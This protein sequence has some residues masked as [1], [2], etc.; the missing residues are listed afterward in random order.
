MTDKSI[1][2]RQDKRTDEPDDASRQGIAP[3]GVEARA[4]AGLAEG[5]DVFRDRPLWLRYLA[6]LALTVVAVGLRRWLDTLGEGVVAF[7]LFYLVVLAC[8]FFGGVGPGLVS[9]GA[10]AVAVTIFWL[11]PVG[12]L[13]LSGTTPINLAL[14]ILTSGVIILIAHLLRAAHSRLRQSEARLS[15][16]QDVGRI[17]V[18]ELDLRSGEPWWSPMFYEVTGISPD[19][20]SGVRSFLDRIDPADR[21]RAN[22]AFEAARDGRDKL[23]AQFRFNRD[24]GATVWLTTR[25]ELFRDADGQPSRLL[26]ITFDV[27]SVRAIESERNRAHTLLRTFFDSLPGAAYV[28]DAEGRILLGNPG[29]AAAVG[30]APESFLG[31]TDPEFLSDAEFA[32]A[33]VEH[34]RALLREGVSRQFEEDLVLPDGELSHWLSVKTP[35]R[36]AE[37][38]IA[39]LVG[40]SLDMTERRRA[41]RR[42]RFLANEV[43]HRAKN[44]MG[45]VQSIVRLTR[46]D[47]IAG[48]KEALTG[49][50][51]ALAR[52]HNLLAASRWEGVELGTLVNEELAP[53]VRTRGAQIRVS[54]PTVKLEPSASQAVTMALH[55][56]AINAARYGAL[57]VESGELTVAWQIVDRG[58]R[59]CLELVWTEARGP[60]VASRV[61]PGFGSTAIRG[62]IEH[63]LGGEIDIDWAPTGVVCRIAFPVAHSVVQD[64]PVAGPAGR[65]RGAGTATSPRDTD[66][67]GKRVLIL[68]DEALIAIT[69]KEAVEALGCE[70]VGPAGNA[71]AALDLIKARAPE[72]AILDVNLAGAS[73]AP[74]AAALR[75]L[76]I[77]FVY[78]TGYAEPAGQIEP[79]L[80]AAMLTKPVDPDELAAA[81]QRALEG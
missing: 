43:D 24:D 48:F 4:Y 22:A 5:F 59:S 20:A 7:T 16:S 63:Q 72:L 2:A 37:G 52:A 74:V 8:T 69:L 56:L 39:G 76:D 17:G 54:G 50:I 77:P 40:I 15:L 55:E 73:S 21:D 67:A 44:L 32:R 45:V 46:A 1:A 71:E 27:T 28:K 26:G 35:F 81:L 30:H 68:D 70:V 3:G 51:R 19:E 38:R 53:F 12:A 25:A 42:L 11:A 6:A 23:D 49:R 47:D 41:E 62:A 13:S 14:F 36:D 66:L 33:V 65:R 64:Q 80:Q 60:V 31:K 10:S 79:D 9:L 57:S 78:C 34:D 61:E 18:W 75:A 29:F 58:E